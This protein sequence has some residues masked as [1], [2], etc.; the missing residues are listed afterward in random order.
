M[1]SFHY[2]TEQTGE[3]I[4]KLLREKWQGGK[5]SVHQMRMDKSVTDTEGQPVEWKEPLPEGTE[6][7]FGFTDAQSSYKPE[8]S[9]SLRVLWEDEHI[10]AVFKPAGVSVHPEHLP[11]TGTLMNEVMGYIEAKGGTYAEHIHRLDQHTAGVLLIAKHP[12]AKTMFDRMLEQNQIER[13]YTAELEGQLRK[14]RGSINM[15]IGKDRYHATKR[16]VSPSGQSAITHFKVLER[17]PDT[18][19]VEA[20]LETGR[21][22][23]IRVHFSHLGHPVVGD[24]LYGSETMSRG[25]YKLVAT[26]VAFTHPITSEMIVVETE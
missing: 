17:K 2:T 9:D 12:L 21:T 25:P 8:P 19:L 23:Q 24:Q 16:R 22:H 5:K 11:G 15:P 4:E 1:T 14:P 3:T 6:L 7:I 10:L 20:Q 26:K 18:T 13:Y